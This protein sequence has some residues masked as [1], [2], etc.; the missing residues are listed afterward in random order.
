MKKLIDNEI[1]S[2]SVKKHNF[3]IFC[4]SYYT[5]LL[6]LCCFW[7]ETSIFEWLFRLS[8]CV[9]SVSFAEEIK[10]VV[11]HKYFV[12]ILFNFCLQLYPNISLTLIGFGKVWKQNSLNVVSLRWCIQSTLIYNKLTW[13]D[14]FLEPTTWD[15]LLTSLRYSLLFWLGCPDSLPVKLR[16]PS[17]ASHLFDSKDRL[18]SPVIS[19]TS[20]WL[21]PVIGNNNDNN[22]LTIL[23]RG[24]QPPRLQILRTDREGMIDDVITHSTWRHMCKKL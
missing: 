12:L 10:S 14:L 18:T 6:I 3:Y 24:Y 5:A 1:R 2:D 17:D 22:F 7:I 19:F 21:L 13:S 9:P 11:S 20:I 4:Y 23:L 16:D 8:G 15:T